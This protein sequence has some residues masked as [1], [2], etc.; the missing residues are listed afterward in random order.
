MCTD[1]TRNLGIRNGIEESRLRDGSGTLI[2]IHSDEYR[3]HQLKIFYRLH[4][5]TRTKGGVM[6]LFDLCELNKI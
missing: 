6:N 4:D 2:L 5:A 1:E 3:V